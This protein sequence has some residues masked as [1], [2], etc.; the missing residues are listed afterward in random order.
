M[1]PR[2]TS[3]AIFVLVFEVECFNKCSV[4]FLGGHWGYI[5]VYKTH[6]RSAWE[7][8]RPIARSVLT[9]VN[10]TQGKCIRFS[11]PQPRI[12]DVWDRVVSMSEFKEMTRVINLRHVKPRGNWCYNNL[13]YY[14]NAWN[15]SRIGTTRPSDKLFQKLLHGFLWY[16]GHWKFLNKISFTLSWP[17]ILVYSS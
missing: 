6:G 5:R 8:A 2:P 12:L 14:V 17:S 16:W 15:W 7:M 4:P 11:I 3:V 9:A 13:T 10:T 1:L